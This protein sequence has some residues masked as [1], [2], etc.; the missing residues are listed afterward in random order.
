MSSS[1]TALTNPSCA[2]CHRTQDELPEPMKRCTG[3]RSVLYCSRDCQKLAWKSYKPVCRTTRP[4]ETRPVRSNR[5]TM[6][7]NYLD[8]VKLGGGESS[9]SASGNSG[10]SDDAKTIYYLETS[11][12]HTYDISVSGPY[13]PLDT[14]IPQV[15]HI[16][17]GACQHGQYGFVPTASVKTCADLASTILRTRCFPESHTR[18][19]RRG[20]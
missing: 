11:T 6:S 13:F 16:F 5:T 3:C 15:M 20:I 19:A 14:I 12:P 1:A 4:G 9:V 2:R 17:G 8:L 10:G 7:M 18:W